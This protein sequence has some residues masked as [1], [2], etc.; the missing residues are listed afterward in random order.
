MKTW[1]KGWSNNKSG[2]W[3]SCVDH[4]T[5]WSKT[6]SSWISISSRSTHQTT[7]RILRCARTHVLSRKLDREC[8][9]CTRT[10]TT[11]KSVWIELGEPSV[12]RVVLGHRNWQIE[13][14][15]WN[16]AGFLHFVWKPAGSDLSSFLLI[17]RNFSNIK[18][19]TFST[20]LKLPSEFFRK[21]SFFDQNQQPLQCR[22]FWKNSSGIVHCTMPVQIL[23]FSRS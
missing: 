5:I 10:H 11:R 22:A 12:Y 17:Y 23:F 21:R 2:F 7:V 19:L 3:Q 6:N 1:K 4:M 8:I 16:L 18:S 14:T 15:A 20:A 9:A 13:T